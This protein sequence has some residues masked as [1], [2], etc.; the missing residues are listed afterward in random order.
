MLVSFALVASQDST[1]GIIFNILE[2]IE[3]NVYFAPYLILFNFEPLFFI[4]AYRLVL[5]HL[6]FKALGRIN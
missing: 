5:V 4:G 2:L 3:S 1:E 6:L